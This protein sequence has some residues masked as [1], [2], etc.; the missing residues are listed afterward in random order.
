MDRGAS[1]ASV[2]G[3]A[4]VG[5]NLVTKPQT[6]IKINIKVSSGKKRADFSA[7]VPDLKTVGP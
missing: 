1:Q 4:R 7:N 2:H 6:C 3:I 5:H